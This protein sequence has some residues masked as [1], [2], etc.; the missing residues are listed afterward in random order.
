MKQENSNELKEI[1]DKLEKFRDNIH[2]YDY[3]EYVIWHLDE[4]IKQL[5]RI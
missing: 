1:L 3:D 4:A 2:D 5:K